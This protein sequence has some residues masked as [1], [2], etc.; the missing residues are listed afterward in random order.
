MVAFR[1]CLQVCELK[2]LRFS[3]LPFTYDN[4]I[5]GKSN[6]HVC[7]DR[8]LADNSWRDI[9]AESVV[10]HL[11]SPCS[12]HCPI[13]LTMEKETRPTF[14]GRCLRYE[15]FWEWDPAMKEVIDMAWRELRPVE[16]L[17]SVS[18]AYM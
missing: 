9:Y 12:D 16:D 11:V 5:V 8:A 2:D 1:D 14:Q 7:L 10:V 3:G 13:L 6:V 15:I 18:Q 4:K 17:A